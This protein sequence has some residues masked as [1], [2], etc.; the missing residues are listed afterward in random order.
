MYEVKMGS[1]CAQ[2][3]TA[4]SKD[5]TPITA[6]LLMTIPIYFSLQQRP[7]YEEL[8]TKPIKYKEKRYPQNACK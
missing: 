2:H 7:N 1:C 3:L 4:N 8:L 5:K 6:I